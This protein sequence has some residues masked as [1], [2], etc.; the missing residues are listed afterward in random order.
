MTRRPP[1]SK[2]LPST[3][4]FRSDKEVYYKLAVIYEY[5]GKH[6][7]AGLA[8]K[9]TSLESANKKEIESIAEDETFVT[10]SEK[11]SEKY[12]KRSRAKTFFRN[13]FFIVGPIASAAGLGLFIHDKAGGENS[14]TAQYT[15]M[16]GGMSL[17]S[18]AI[19]LNASA[20]DSL[21]VSN[22]YRG[23]PQ[24]FRGDG[25]TT[26]D[27]YFIYSGEEKRDRKSVV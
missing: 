1:I 21:R 23:F 9:K 26:P 12:S 6:Y 20:E 7:L 3:T 10:M 27:E 2:V 22:S 17:I 14:L 4:L 5:I 24:C 25:G 13:A 16:L 11:F 15:L 8:Y 18:G 19:I